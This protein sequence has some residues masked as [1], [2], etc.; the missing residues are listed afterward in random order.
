MF[1]QTEVVIVKNRILALLLTLTVLICSIPAGR[2]EQQTLSAYEQYLQDGTIPS[3][4]EK[5][6]DSFLIGVAVPADLMENTQAK[7]LIVSQFSSLTCENE[8][9][10]DFTLSYADTRRKNDPEHAVV[11]PS[12]CKK[13]LAF[14]QKS[15]I[16]VRAHTLI[17]HSQTPRWFFT[18]EW[19]SSEHAELADR[20]TMIKRME[21]YIHDMM[22]WVNE[23]YP[24]V[25]YAWDVVN[26][27]I[28]PGNGHPEGLRTENNLWY[29][30][31]GDDWVELAF[32]FAR[33]YAAE[34]QKLFY[35]DYGCTDSIK[36]GKIRPLLKKLKE[37]G[38][39][40]GLGMQFHIGTDSPTVSEME[41][42]ITNYAHLGLT[43]HLTEMDI[44]TED[45][46]AMGQMQLAVR[47]R[48]IFSLMQRLKDRAGLDIESITFWGLSDDRSWLNSENSAKYPLLFDRNLQPKAA[49]FGAMQD[50]SIPWKNDET[51]LQEVIDRLGL[52]AT[53]LTEGEMKVYKALPQHN[54]VMTQKFG[55]DPWAMVYGDRVYLYMT[56]D[57]PVTGA[58]GSVQTNTYGNIRT[59]RVLSS[60]DLVNWTDHGAIPAAGRSGTAKWANNSWAPCAAWKNID[61]KD[62]FFLY[63]ADNG[64]GI[65]VLTA[66]SPIGPF[67]DPIGKQ[68]VSRG[69]PTCAEVTWLFDPAVLVDDDGEAYLYF[70]GGIPDGKASAP[71]T[72]RAVKLGADMIHLDGDPVRLDPPWLFEDSGIN[73]I[74]DTYVYSYCTNFNVPGSGSEQ[75]FQS[76]EI[77]TMTSENPLGPFTYAARVL[78]N[79]GTYFGVGGNN[80]HS[81]FQFK[82]E[83]YIAYH[84]ATVDRDK[85]W[86][87]GYRSTFIDR[88][89]LDENGLPA[90]SEGTMAGVPQLKHLDPYATQEAETLAVIAGAEVPEIA[91]ASNGLAVKSAATGGWIGVAGADFGT[92][93]A[94][95][96]TIQYRSTT[97]GKI[98]LRLDDPESEDVA[99]IALKSTDAFTAETFELPQA[100]QGIHDLYICFDQPEI[101]LDTWQFD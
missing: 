36:F 46:S 85:G 92:E 8:M 34:G 47:Y 10:P 76:G 69:T 90:L 98:M 79:P 51:L 6:Q 82:G 83:W 41:T 49:F 87:A 15:G 54:P 16:Q 50:S 19:D 33:K 77:V 37:A 80:H 72:A 101:Y 28:E 93:G 73:K 78:K 86:N 17:W 23:K 13:T 74:G 53:G 58:D 38:I 29:T 60:D 30:T 57:E 71:G 12:K 99:V 68:L 67:T 44:G 14:A 7:D 63:F 48:T 32:T 55:A 22:D 24:G 26:E 61:G 59:I 95:K 20:E 27:A 40:D 56:G 45:G 11:F 39:L 2:A 66:D 62:K 1:I 97:G 4:R 94:K 81:M 91:G 89:A 84:A 64:S 9:K 21:N 52:K 42:V 18:K 35:N 88:L 5:Y 65:G 96:I 100:V 70:G 43:I 31:I 25:V 3:L 75:G